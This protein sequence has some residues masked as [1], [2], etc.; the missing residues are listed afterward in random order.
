MFGSIPSMKLQTAHNAWARPPPKLALTSENGMRRVPVPR[1]SNRSDTWNQGASCRRL[2]VW[3]LNTDGLPGGCSTP[4]PHP[5]DPTSL[6]GWPEAGKR[7]GW[8]SSE[9]L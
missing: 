8:A 6:V 7:V 5:A 3:G 2:A 4:P 1:T 9:C